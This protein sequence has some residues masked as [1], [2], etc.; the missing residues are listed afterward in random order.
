MVQMEFKEKS[1]IGGRDVSVREILIQEQ[2]FRMGVFALALAVAL[3]AGS[4]TL[5]VCIALLI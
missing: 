5:L 2:R 1:L 3:I 4:G